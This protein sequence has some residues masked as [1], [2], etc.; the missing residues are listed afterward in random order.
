MKIVLFF[1]LWHVQ[2]FL[3]QTINLDF[4]HQFFYLFIYLSLFFWM[5][6]FHFLTLVFVFVLF[7]FSITWSWPP[8]KIM[9]RATDVTFR[10][11]PI[12]LQGVWRGARWCSWGNPGE[13]LLRLHKPVNGWLNT[14]MSTLS[15]KQLLIRSAG[16]WLSRTSSQALMLRC[17]APT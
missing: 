4:T 16:G 8:L 3:R 6:L 15:R 12:T 9:E 17:K 14:R 10:G 11:W 7:C 1:S 2:N 5:L 13:C